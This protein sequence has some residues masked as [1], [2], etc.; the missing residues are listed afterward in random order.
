MKFEVIVGNPPYSRNLHL[1][2]IG[3][4]IKLLKN[5][6][7]AIFIHPIDKLISTKLIYEPYYIKEYNK[8]EKILKHCNSVKKIGMTNFGINIQA[9]CGITTWKVDEVENWSPD[10]YASMKYNDDEI[11]IIKKIMKKIRENGDVNNLFYFVWNRDKETDIIQ[12][13]PAIHGN[14]NQDGTK[15]NDF[16]EIF[17]K[18]YNKAIQV[19]EQKNRSDAAKIC[20]DTED[21]RRNFINSTF[22]KAHKI[23][24]SF[25]KSDC[26]IRLKF[27]PWLQ[28]YSKPWTD[29]MIMDFFELTGDEK[30][31][32][33]NIDINKNY[34]NNIDSENEYFNKQVQLASTEK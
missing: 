1:N 2:I 7:M 28:D 8:L 5:D 15:Y 10:K 14:L 12:W 33:M 19:K 24:M 23:I 34:V 22:L 27:I 26:N 25:W 3:E 18:D 11:L 17:S 13:I 30:K 32:F 21:E 16:Y 9:D 29:D 20:F 6:G 4:V 31:V